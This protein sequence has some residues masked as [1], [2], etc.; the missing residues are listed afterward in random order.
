MGDLLDP[1]PPQWKRRDQSEGEQG[2]DLTLR[3][4]TELLEVLTREVVPTVVLLAALRMV[5][6]SVISTY[7]MAYGRKQA[8]AMLAQATIMAA[9][10]TIGVSHGPTDD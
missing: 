1:Q 4:V 9:Q 7:Q 8:K 2:D 10:Y 6:K 5:Q 3:V